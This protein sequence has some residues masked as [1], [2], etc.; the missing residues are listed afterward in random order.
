VT[1]DAA[2]SWAEILARLML[3]AVPASER[4]QLA[5]E[6]LA[7]AD[8]HGH[9]A[10]GTALVIGERVEL[11][12][13]AP[14]VRQPGWFVAFFHD[15]DPECGRGATYRILADDRQVWEGPRVRRLR[16]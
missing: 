5:S 1:V 14:A 3:H 2:I 15:D 12:S 16:A 9:P 7:A 10:L 6:L 11:T 8:L 4:E 13:W